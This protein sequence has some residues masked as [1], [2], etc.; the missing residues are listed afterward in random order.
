MPDVPAVIGHHPEL[1]IALAL[2][3]TY[4]TVA[5]ILNTCRVPIDDWLTAAGVRS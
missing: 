2:V 3:G 4:R 1:L 5:G